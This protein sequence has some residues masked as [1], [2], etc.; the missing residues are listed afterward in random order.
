MRHGP[1][2]FQSQTWKRLYLAAL[3]ENNK[4]RLP[5]KIAEAQNAALRRRSELLSQPDSDTLERQA[6]DTALFSLQ[7]LKSC[8]VTASA[9]IA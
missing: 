9:A 2:Q 6:L 5:L 7:A 4:S 1:M 8:L 3:F